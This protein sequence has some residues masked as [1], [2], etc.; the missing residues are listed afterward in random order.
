MPLY[1]K[2]DGVVTGG[3]QSCREAQWMDTDFWVGRAN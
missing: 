2:F 1:E 3:L